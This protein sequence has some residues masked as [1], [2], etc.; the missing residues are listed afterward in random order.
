M[1]RQEAVLCRKS[2]KR[3][4][5]K[6]IPS[7]LIA[8]LQE[9]ITQ[10]NAESGLNM[11]MVLDQGEAFTGFLRSYGLFSGVQNYLL[12]IGEKEDKNLEEKAGFFAEQFVLDATM[13]CIDTSWV[14]ATFDR[15]VCPVEIE[16]KE[17]I[18]AAI[19]FGYRCDDSK[20]LDKID[21]ILYKVMHRKKMKPKDFYKAHSQVPDWFLAGIEC[22][23]HAP[24]AVNRRP[25]RFLYTHHGRVQAYV[26]FATPY[27]MV[28]LGVAKLH[29]AIGAGQ[30]KWKYG[31]YGEFSY[32]A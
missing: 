17:R 9:R 27:N 22:V 7:A 20:E 4:S 13:L 11:Q 25:I 2:T 26:R 8:Q 1:T 16:E 24:S 5:K 14:G 19:V 23:L 28:D 32:D 18:V 6:S 15:K 12:I 30:G 10:Y 21:S 3:Y 31:D 29:F